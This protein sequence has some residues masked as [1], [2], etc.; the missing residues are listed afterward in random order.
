VT[1]SGFGACNQGAAA[2]SKRSGVCHPAPVELLG[3]RVDSVVSGS[4]VF[5]ACSVGLIRISEPSPACTMSNPSPPS[6]TQP[7][8][9]LLPGQSHLP[10][11]LAHPSLRPPALPS[12]QSS[13]SSIPSAP[14][15]LRDVHGRLLNPRSCVTCRKRK[16]KCDKLHPCS[17]C[18][19]AHIECVFPTPGRAPRKPRKVSDSRDVELLDRLRR[20]EG[21]VKGLGVDITNPDSFPDPP[22]DSHEEAGTPELS[23]ITLPTVRTCPNPPDPTHSNKHGTEDE[24][25]RW[26]AKNKHMDESRSNKF[27]TRF[28]RLV[29]NEGRS[30]YVNNSFWANLSNEVEDLKGIL[31]QNTDDE[32]DD[33][34]PIQSQPDQHHA[35]IFSFSSQNVDLLSLHPI[36]GQIEAYWNIY[37]ERVDPLVKVLHIPTIEPTVLA[38]AS[39][40]ANLS[41]SFEA[42]LFAIYYGAIT[43]LSEDECLNKLG[44]EKGL[45]LSRYRFGVEQALARAN[46]LTT[47]EMMVVQAI[48]IYLICLRRNN[49]ARVIWTLTGLVVR[50]AQTL[51][52][53]RDGLHFNLPPFEIEMRRRLW[54][55]ICILDVRASEDHGSDPTI[56]KF[57]FLFLKTGFRCLFSY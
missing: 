45:L 44:E 10:S 25:E 3:N 12:A 56:S 23:E 55:Q 40:L 19:R 49:D 38:S 7:N 27:E 33:P 5:G 32:A 6:P 11:A 52:V 37:K 21:V 4:S 41:K 53:H 17:N 8:S 28:G 47:E 34:S 9:I 35:W 51:G 26:A 22:P 24:H 14:A 18:A 15:P 13:S 16:V 42:L 29:I 57:T 2:D 48:V 39:H 31:N 30:R 43:S 54:W 46:F 36:A 50:I 1:D 20:L